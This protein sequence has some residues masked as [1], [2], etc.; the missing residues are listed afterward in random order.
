MLLLRILE[1]LAFFS[2]FVIGFTQV[3]LPAWQ[4][5]PLFPVFRKSKPEQTGGSN[6]S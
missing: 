4:G 3:I 6:G 1:G 2:V 5:S